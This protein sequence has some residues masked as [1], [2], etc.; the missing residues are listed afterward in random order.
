MVHRIAQKKTSTPSRPKMLKITLTEDMVVEGVEKWFDK[1]FIPKANQLKDYSLDGSI[2]IVKIS[3]LKRRDEE[4]YITGRIELPESAKQY[5]VSTNPEKTVPLSLPHLPLQAHYWTSSNEVYEY[6]VDSTDTEWISRKLARLISFDDI[7]KYIAQFESDIDDIV[8]LN[9][10]YDAISRGLVTDMSIRDE[11]GPYPRNVELE[12]ITQERT[13]I[14][15]ISLSRSLAELNPA[16]LK[17][18]LVNPYDC[19]IIDDYTLECPKTTSYIS[20]VWPGGG[21]PHF[22]DRA[23]FYYSSLNAISGLFPETLDLSDEE[24]WE[25]AKDTVYKSIRSHNRYEFPFDVYID[26]KNDVIVE[27]LRDEEH[28]YGGKPM[29]IKF[30]NLRDLIYYD[31]WHYMSRIADDYEKRY[32]RAFN[33]RMKEYGDEE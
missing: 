14:T 23:P 33:Y 2:Y 10:Q 28:T 26:S 13:F 22:E 12:D 19:K 30:A 29:K 5:C 18:H 17:R 1:Y 11:Y 3:H 8:N 7:D 6:L 16:I 24:L 31:D 4:I 15:T 20:F 21:N 25:V 27:F 32:K 9:L